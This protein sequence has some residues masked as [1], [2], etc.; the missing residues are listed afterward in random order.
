MGQD[1]ATQKRAKLLLNEAGRGLIA[2]ARTRQEAFQ[3]LS[4]DLMKQGLLWLTA[5][6]LGH[7]VS[8]WDRRGERRETS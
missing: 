4:D 3:L 8:L 1:A 2:I 6:V 7:G 5:L